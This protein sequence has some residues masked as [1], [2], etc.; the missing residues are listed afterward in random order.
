M[1][2]LKILEASTE[3]WNMAFVQKIYEQIK[4]LVNIIMS[5]PKRHP[6]SLCRRNL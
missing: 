5:D 6:Q 3:V 1:Q 4:K 2:N